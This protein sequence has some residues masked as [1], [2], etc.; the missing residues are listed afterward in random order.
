[1]KHLCGKW[2]EVDSLTLD[3]YV[4]TVL[5]A[6]VYIIVVYCWWNHFSCYII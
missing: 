1:V 4:V 3:L 6:N 5:P 2:G